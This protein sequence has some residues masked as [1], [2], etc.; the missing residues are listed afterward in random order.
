M[1]DSSYIDDSTRAE[2][3][4]AF[5]HVLRVQ[6]S[7][8]RGPWKPGFSRLWIDPHRVCDL[9]TWI[10]EFGAD[11]MPAKANGFHFGCGVRSFRQI[12]QWFG[13]DELTI[14]YGYGYQI[15]SMR[16]DHIIAESKNQNIFKRKLPLNVDVMPVKL[17]NYLSPGQLVHA[18]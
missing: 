2:L 1:S 16:V 8:G 11:A 17:E 5:D 6:D 15:V 13:D 4:R 18:L 7:D 10:E 9:P 3:F 12:G 14:L